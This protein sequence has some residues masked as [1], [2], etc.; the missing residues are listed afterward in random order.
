MVN[1]LERDILKVLVTEEEIQARVGQLGAELAERFQGKDPMF[2]GVLRGCFIFMA[3]LIRACPIK[4]DLEFIAVS[5]YQNATVSSGRVEITHD[6]QQDI[7]GRELIVVEDILDSGNTLAY[8]KQYLLT[9]GA[10]SITI[11]TLLDKP[12][13]RQKA[14]TAD[15]IGFTVPDEFVVGYGLDYGQR[16]RNLPYIGILKPEVY[17]K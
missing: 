15:Y 17:T 6:V 9:K 1:E 5:S 4:S 13:R 16:Y 14:V 2:F 10:A 3:D 12:S 8:L 7:T 11:A